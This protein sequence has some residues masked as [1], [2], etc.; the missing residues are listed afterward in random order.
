MS[1]LEIIIFVRMFLQ[2]LLEEYKCTILSKLEESGALKHYRALANKDVVWSAKRKMR[3][4]SPLI[5]VKKKKK[6]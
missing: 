2:R 4:K 5:E 6:T 3:S 1:C